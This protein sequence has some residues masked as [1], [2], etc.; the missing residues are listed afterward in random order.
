MERRRSVEY[1]EWH[2]ACRKEREAW[3]KVSGKLPGSPGYD[4]ASW[5]DWQELLQRSTDALDRYLK[6]RNELRREIQRKLPPSA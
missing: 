3:A 2:A 4:P 6:S 5:G 1:E